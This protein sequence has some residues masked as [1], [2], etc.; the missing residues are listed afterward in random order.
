M[1]DS[2]PEGKR[3]LKACND[4]RQSRSQSRWLCYQLIEATLEGD[5]M[6]KVRIDTEDPLL[7][8]AMRL[9]GTEDP[10]VAVSEALKFAIALRDGEAEMRARYD[11]LK[12]QR[13]GEDAPE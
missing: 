12:R 8:E 7:L 4:R 3:A 5:H 11:A 9:C 1:A 10:A 6:V 13:E 2:P